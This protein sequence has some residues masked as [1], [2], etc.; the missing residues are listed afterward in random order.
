MISLWLKTE[1]GEVNEGRPLVSRAV[2]HMDGCTDVSN[3]CIERCCVWSASFFGSNGSEEVST[4]SRL[5]KCASVRTIYTSIL[6]IQRY[7][8]LS[9]R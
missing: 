9:R 5:W 3:C 8:H 4:L 6:G 2:V 1:I 7:Q